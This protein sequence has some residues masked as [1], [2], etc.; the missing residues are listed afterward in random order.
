[1]IADNVSTKECGGEVNMSVC[2]RVVSIWSTHMANTNSVITKYIN[3]T[4]LR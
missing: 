1:M 3:E 4:F 2:G